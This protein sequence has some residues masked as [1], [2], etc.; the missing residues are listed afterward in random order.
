[1]KSI[2]RIPKGWNASDIPSQSGRRFLITGGTSGIGLETARELIR[3]GGEVI[4]AAR[5][6]IKAEQTVLALGKERASWIECDVASLT[7]VRNAAR[8]VNGE[9]DVLILNAG[10]MAIPFTSNVDGFEMQMATNHIGHFALAALLRERV[11]HRVVTV[12][13]SAHRMGDFGGGSL[14]EIEERIIAER[15][16]DSYSPW[17]VYGNSKLANMLFG[18]E[19]E[20]RARRDGLGF[21]SLVVH[22]GYAD[23]NLQY[24][25]A[26][27]T[28]DT[29][30]K[31]AITWMNRILAQ[32]ASRG[33]L[34]TLAA[35]T[36][37]SLHGG[38]LIGPDGL[39][40]MRGSPR[41]TRARSLAYDQQLASNLWHVSERLAAISW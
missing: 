11:R 7:S 37:E 20:R 2:Y 18:F 28:G 4:I 32:D 9:I 19:L 12:S 31:K 36:I 24:V 21:A 8:Q 29:S 25:A 15:I 14:E 33:A 41:L 17:R 34:P 40:E 39:F 5:N 26:E 22:P 3:A 1:M 35:A 23:T 38:A 27:L 10:V 30:R 6:P 13:S 16:E